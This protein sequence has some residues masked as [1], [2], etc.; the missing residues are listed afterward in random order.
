MARLI[1]TSENQIQRLNGIL[2]KVEKLQ[3][4]PLDRLTMSPHEKSWCVAEVLEHLNIAYRLY[5]DKINHALEQLDAIDSDSKEFKARAWQ[6]M[7]IEM[8]RPKNGK[9][10]WKIKTMKRFEPV[11]EVSSLDQEQVNVVFENFFSLHAHLKDAI[12]QSRGMD[13]RGIKITSAIGPIVNFYLPEA[14]EFLLC[15]L[16]R[17]L[18]QIDKVLG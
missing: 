11:L 15:H 7:V 16:E 6:K 12:L 3:Q 10:K 8:Q 5:F 2:G 4:L 14:F 17:H 18:V 9:R 1:L 13:V